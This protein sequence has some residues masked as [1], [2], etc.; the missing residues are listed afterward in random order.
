MKG[1]DR[2]IDSAQTPKRFDGRLALLENVTKTLTDTSW[3]C[4]IPTTQKM[5]P[6]RL[7]SEPG[8][9]TVKPILFSKGPGE[10]IE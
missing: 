9:F 8:K 2:E 4:Q 10:M 7:C 3:Y 5:P 6:P 1:D